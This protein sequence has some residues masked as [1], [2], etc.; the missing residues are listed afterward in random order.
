MSGVLYAQKRHLAQGV[1]N[2]FV[3]LL[4]L[5][6]LTKQIKLVVGT[7]ENKRTKHIRKQAGIRL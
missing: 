5:D 7:I 3:L 1:Q 2:E 4:Y 6:L